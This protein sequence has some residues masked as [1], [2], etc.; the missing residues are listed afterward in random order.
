[1]VPLPQAVQDVLGRRARLDCSGP[2][3]RTVR[4]QTQHVRAWE[5][6]KTYGRLI[7]R[8]AG[9]ANQF[10]VA[11]QNGGLDSSGVFGLAAKVA[12]APP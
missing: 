2:L 8:G 11:A 12:I 7:V 9:P 4:P 5:L 1:M 3:V 10:I 6:K